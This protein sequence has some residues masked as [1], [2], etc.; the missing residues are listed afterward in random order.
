MKRIQSKSKRKRPEIAFFDYPDVFEDFWP[1]YKLDQKSF[2]DSPTS[3]S[4]H[5]QMLSLLQRNIGD[6]QWYIFSLNPKQKH[7]HHSKLGCEVN[8]FKSSRLHIWLW[9]LFWMSNSSWRWRNFFSCHSTILSYASILSFTFM[10]EF[11]KNKPDFMFVQ[12]Y[13][14]GRFDVLVLISKMLK[15][16][17]ICY[18]SGSQPDFYLGKFLKRWSIPRADKIII[19]DQ[20]QFTLL[21]NQYNV[22]T[23]SLKKIY[24]LADTNTFKP[25]NRQEACRCLGIN[26]DN[27][28]FLFMGRLVDHIKQVSTLIRA[29]SE[30]AI[31][32]KDIYLIIA[33][34]GPDLRIL[35][36]IAQKSFPERIYFVGWVED[37][38]KKIQL[39][40]VA[41]C[42]ILPSLREGCPA[43]IG[44]A[45][46][47]GLPVLASRVGSI[48][49]LVLEGQTGWLI[50][51][52]SEWDLKEKMILVLDQ[53]EV[54][55]SMREKA[56]KMAENT[57]SHSVVNK[58]LQK[59]FK[60]E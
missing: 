13:S 18:H 20:E 2:F 4:G 8:F 7:G 52:G 26:A 15:I 19:S 22:S 40:N 50:K 5:Y 17:L 39:Y 30:L 59:C 55:L 23:T 16:P 41:Q 10:K 14:S 51:P 24:T 1:H 57:V 21:K 49:E 9:N 6:V 53:P 60:I 36:N 38:Q 47:C 48:S 34:D 28:Y 32:R 58:K 42:L 45:L 31:K 56:R 44:E 35:Q 54:V 37:I 43:V 25:M 12:D 33:G 3:A 46:A 11:R 29:F 27:K